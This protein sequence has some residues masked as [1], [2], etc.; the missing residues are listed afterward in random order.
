MHFKQAKTF[1]II[2]GVIFICLFDT[3]RVLRNYS[4]QSPKAIFPTYSFI[5]DDYETAPP[6]TPGNCQGRI[7][8]CLVRPSPNPLIGKSY[9][10]SNQLQ[11]THKI[12]MIA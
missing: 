9:S 6:V 4:P 3:C 12:A 11:S 5:S 1:V 7:L 2:S 8:M 10:Y